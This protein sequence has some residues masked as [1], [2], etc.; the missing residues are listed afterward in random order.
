[1][2]TLL[3]I[4]L[5]GVTTLVNAEIPE[6]TGYIFDAALNT[7]LQDVQIQVGNTNIKTYTDANGHFHFINLP[8]DT[9][10]IV[11]TKKGY[12][13]EKRLI[14]LKKNKFRKISLKLFPLAY[15]MPAVI[16][17]DKIY[18]N[19]FDELHEF[20][21]TVEDAELV[22]ELGAT[23]ASTLGNEVGISMRTMGPAPARPVIR[24]LGGNRIAMAEDGLNIV[25]LSATSSDH[26][27]TI[28]PSTVERIEILRGPKTLLNTTTTIGGVVNIIRNDIPLKSFSKLS[29][30]A[31]LYGETV[32]SGYNGALSLEIPIWKFGFKGNASYR[33]AANLY[34]PEGIIANTQIENFTFSAGTGFIEEDYSVGIGINQFGS[35]YGIPGGFV[36]AHPNGVNISML[37]RLIQGK[38]LFHFRDKIFDVVE[39][40]FGR[41]YYKHTEFESNGSIGAE[42]LFR[43]YA[44]RINVNHK[45]GKIFRE[46]SFGITLNKQNIEYGGYVFTAPTD[47]FSLAPYIYESIK[48][49][50][51]YLEFGIRYSYTKITP[52]QDDS[53]KI[54]L[55]RQRIFNTFSASLSVMHEVQKDFF[56]GVNLSRTTRTPTANE[57]FSL[58]P[59]LASYSFDIGN[60]NL[61]EESGYGSELFA[62]LRKDKM[63]ASITG[64]FNYMNYY[65]ITQ[66][67]GLENVQQLLP[68]Y[69]YSGVP[70]I[71][72]GFEMSYRQIIV[73]QLLLNTILSYTAAQNTETE[74]AL[75]FIPPLKGSINID[76]KPLQEL[77]VT[78]TGDFAAAQHRLGDFEEPTDGYFVLNL[79]A[80]YSFP[81]GNTLS[82]IALSFDNIFNTIY[83]N[84]LSRIK[85][86]YPEPGR[87]LRLTYKLN[88]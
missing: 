15:N 33:K 25:D 39:A 73:K 61:D 79:S 5:F 51:H 32:N 3:F 86:V 46:G 52:E 41:T 23:I 78:V 30:S 14:D 69:A 70:A 76:Y 26:A 74:K 29:G 43:N 45:K 4:L 21:G 6:L 54:G 81:V 56:L 50:K 7:P 57:L 47:N 67:T 12:I 9:F 55:I 71:L 37:K 44:A 20:T 63:T 34:T 18:G 13:S 65:I 28:D 49:G 60:P 64:F 31:L 40:D 82:S 10:T 11:I 66:N 2:K 38:A 8:N 36:G 58:G 68:I 85:S 1:M 59:H 62:F 19:K 42:Y 72:Y 48:L 75:P 22:K 17:T 27:V 84:H 87:N 53:S 83:R 88:I 35:D 77:T 16:V 80:L 24:G